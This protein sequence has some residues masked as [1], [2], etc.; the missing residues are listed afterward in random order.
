M[1][2]VQHKH[3][4]T[5]THTHTHGNKM[6]TPLVPLSRRSCDSKSR[7]KWVSLIM[8]DVSHPRERG[9]RM[10]LVNRA[11]FH[12]AIRPADVTALNNFS[13]PFQEAGGWGE[14]SGGWGGC[15]ECPGG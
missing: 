12:A 5:H 9:K 4:H 11:S 14:Y 15:E 8:Y 3:N 10:M 2:I 6:R 13:Q 7:R 1:A